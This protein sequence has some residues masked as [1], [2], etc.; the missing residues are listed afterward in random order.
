MVFLEIASIL[1]LVLI[2]ANHDQSS[3][4]YDPR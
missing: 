4:H 3:Y 2:S 1:L